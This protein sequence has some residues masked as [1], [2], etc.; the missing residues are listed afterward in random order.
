MHTGFGLENLKERNSLEDTDVWEDDAMDL[1][2]FRI[3][4][5]EMDS[6]GSGYVA[7]AGSL[8]FTKCGEF[9][10]DSAARC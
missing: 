7:V 3:G 1:K 2:R 8:D 9:L 4:G 6:S 10:K 5:C